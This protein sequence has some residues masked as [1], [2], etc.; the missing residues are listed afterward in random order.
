MARTNIPV[1]TV[2][3]FGGTI[4]ALSLTAADQANDHYFLNDGKTVLIAY[5]SSGS[6]QTVTIPSEAD[7]AGRTG[8]KTIVT[9]ANGVGIGGPFPPKY[10]NSRTPGEENWCKVDLTT[11]TGL[12]FA[13]VSL[14][15][16]GT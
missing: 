16:L 4:S 5:T 15:N 13:A 7:E 12:S 10:F 3:A 11:N 2:A 6:G 14:A 1:Q 8:I 9:G